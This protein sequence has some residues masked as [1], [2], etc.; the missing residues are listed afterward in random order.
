MVAKV[1]NSVFVAAKDVVGEAIDLDVATDGQVGR[2]DKCITLVH[3][4]VL[5]AAEE[6][7]LNNAGV[8]DCG[9]VN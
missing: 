7:T 4:L 8:L 2:S 5:V 9:L 3:V 6:G 1:V